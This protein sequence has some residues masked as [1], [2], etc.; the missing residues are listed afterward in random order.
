MLQSRLHKLESE[1]IGLEN[2]TVTLKLRIHKK[3]YD[4]RK[5]VSFLNV[6]FHHLSLLS[7]M[8]N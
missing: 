6:I 5:R 4:F 2:Y 1:P 7:C 8:R 3:S